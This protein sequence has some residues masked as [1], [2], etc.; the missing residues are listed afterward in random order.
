MAYRVLQYSKL[1]N[2]VAIIQTPFIDSILS[3]YYATHHTLNS[4]CTVACTT[5]HSMCRGVVVF[6]GD[7]AYRSVIVQYDSSTCLT[8]GNLDEISVSLNQSVDSGTVL[9][10][11]V[12]KVYVELLK[13]EGD[14]H[15]WPVRIGANEYFKQD[16]EAI[17]AGEVELPDSGATAYSSQAYPRTFNY[18]LLQPY[19]VTLDTSSPQNIDWASLKTLRVSGAVLDAG[20]LF[21]STHIRQSK[22]MNAKVPKWME[23]IKAAGVLH[24]FYFHGCATNRYEA[25]DEIY[26]L[27][28]VVRNWPA[29]LGVWVVPEFTTTVTTNNMILN[30][31]KD[32]LFELGLD[33]AI[34]IYTDRAGLHKL[35]WADHQSDWLLW[36]VEHC[37]AVSDFDTMLT[38]DFFRLDPV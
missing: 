14:S 17:I 26:E 2:G 38:P 21:S 7:A 36:L 30:I 10:S 22:F 23:D 37:T 15:V 27:S 4:N 32:A 20:R 5:V 28:Y 16:P 3:P 6:V 24:G 35:T 25:Q 33:N 31:Y 1:T 13:S 9:G 34:G 12:D 19:I 11:A 18:E 8:Y 29:S